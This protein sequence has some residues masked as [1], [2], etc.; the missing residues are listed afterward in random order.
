MQYEQM[1]IDNEDIVYDN[2]D[3]SE[4]LRE[5]FNQS[6]VMSED[7]EEQ[8]EKNTTRTSFEESNSSRRQQVDDEQEMDS[9]SRQAN[10]NFEQDLA[11]SDSDDSVNKMEIDNDKSNDARQDDN[12]DDDIWF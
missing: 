2:Y 1:M 5:R 11:M 8:K 9:N 7:D 6:A 3:P 12:E 10:S 4:F